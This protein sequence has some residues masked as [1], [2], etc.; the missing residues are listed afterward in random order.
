MLPV[1]PNVRDWNAETMAAAVAAEPVQKVRYA[2]RRDFEAALGD[3]CR[4]RKSSMGPA[5]LWC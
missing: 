5:S 1:S 4:D 3:T 2:A